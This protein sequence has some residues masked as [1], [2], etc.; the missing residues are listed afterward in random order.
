MSLTG[1]QCSTIVLKVD[2]VDRLE[3]RYPHP[4]MILAWRSDVLCIEVFVFS[5]DL[6]QLPYFPKFVT[7]VIGLCKTT[8]P[9]VLINEDVLS[10]V[11]VLRLERRKLLDDHHVSKL[12]YVSL[13]PA[14]W[15]VELRVRVN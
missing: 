2:H 1:E 12:P 8:V 11:W 15:T 4:A 3:C 14:V 9:K 5:P 7:S 13:R 10:L 6:A